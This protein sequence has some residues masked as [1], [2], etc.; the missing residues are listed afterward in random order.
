MALFHQQFKSG[1][2]SRGFT[3]VEI[4]ASTAILVI[5]AVLLVQG[6]SRYSYRQIHAQ[7]ISRVT[8][9]LT[10]ARQQTIASYENTT[11]GV[12]V[13]TSTIEFFAGTTPTPGAATNTIVTIPGH[14]QATS[15]FSTGN[16]FLSFIRG[17]GAATASGTIT[18]VD[19]RTVATST[20]TI[21]S[22]GL[23]E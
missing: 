9:E 20:I 15:S 19:T 18:I 2:S 14:L 17:T 16:N 5:V 8:D 21:S 13:G 11:Y 12:Y 10:E 4:L 22:L 23:V 3:L 6:F 1:A 7:F